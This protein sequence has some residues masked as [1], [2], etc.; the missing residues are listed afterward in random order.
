MNP[1]LGQLAISLSF[2][3]TVLVSGFGLFGSPAGQQ[4]RGAALDALVLGTF[5]L[6]LFAFGVLV[7]AFLCDD[8]TVRYVADNSNSALPWY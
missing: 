1:E 5:V 8:F 7:A 6:V 3:M 4:R 2:C